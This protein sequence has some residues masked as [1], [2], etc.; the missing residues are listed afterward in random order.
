MTRFRGA[1]VKKHPLFPF[2]GAL[3]NLDLK[4]KIKGH[5]Q[6]A[7]ASKTSIALIDWFIFCLYWWLYVRGSFL[8]RSV[9]RIKIIPRRILP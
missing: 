9:K 2:L 4:K 1:F 7:V 6:C 8:K 3:H 5:A